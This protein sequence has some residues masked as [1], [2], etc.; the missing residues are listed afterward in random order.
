MKIKK[1]TPLIDQH[2]KNFMYGKHGGELVP[3]TLKKPISDL[4]KLF[5]KL[6][7]NK[8][9]LRER[10]DYFKNWVGE[11]PFFK[12]ENLTTHLGG[13]QIW[14]KKVS[15]ARGGAHKIYGAVVHAMLCRR[16]GRRLMATDT[17]A[18]FNGKLMAL[19]C[20]HFGIS[21]KVFMG[22][23]DVERQSENV[24]A[25]KALDATIIPVDTGSATLV[26]AVSDCNR[27]WMANCQTTHMAIGSTVGANIFTKIC[28]WSTAQI[29]RELIVQ[30]KDEFGGE[31]PKKLKLLN[32]VGG[33]SSA[34]GMWNSFMD[35]PKSQVEFVGIEAGGP[36]NS[37]LHAAPLSKGGKLG[38]LHG[39]MQYVL[40]DS[41]A[42]I[43]PTASISAGLDYPGV[44]SLHCF[45]KDCGRARYTNADDESVLEAHKLLTELEPDVRPSLEPLH[46]FSE[47]IRIAPRLNPD[48]V[49]VVNACGDVLKDINIIRERL[50]NKYAQI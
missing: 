33:G 8:S 36:R 6:R 43:M 41:E 27:Y 21:L 2:D 25:I 7:Y 20:K 48:T 46:A 44:S 45:L 49:I 34:I 40:M 1:G 30:I 37:P 15:D 23:Y 28:A 17:G 29:S 31:I 16:S 14:C 19:A 38:I 24:K 35:Y 5:E 47:C 22:T 12:L 26:D 9:F 13:A 39:A 11:T 50:G 3:I 18:G 4:R 42:N 32:C 10:D